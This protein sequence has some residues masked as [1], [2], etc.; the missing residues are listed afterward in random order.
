ML[1]LCHMCMCSVRGLISLVLWVH[2]MEAWLSFSTKCTCLYTGGCFAIWYA[3]T[4]S[5]PPTPIFNSRL[6]EWNLPPPQRLENSHLFLQ[7]SLCLTHAPL[8]HFMTLLSQG[9][10]SRRA[11]GSVGLLSCSFA[12]SFRFHASVLSVIKCMCTSFFSPFPHLGL[13]SF[14]IQ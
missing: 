4:G 12:K 2:N 5:Q 3:V 14:L 1:E 8:A 10:H 7:P 11:M 13:S 6:F 9:M